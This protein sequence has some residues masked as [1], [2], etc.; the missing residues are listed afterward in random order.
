MTIH[1]MARPTPRI[2]F[3]TCSFFFRIFCKSGNTCNIIIMWWRWSRCAITDDQERA[4]WAWP[5]CPVNCPTWAHRA[6]CAGA[7]EGPGPVPGPGPRSGPGHSLNSGRVHTQNPKPKTQKKK[8]NKYP[9][10]KEKRK[11]SAIA[12][13]IQ[14]CRS[15]RSFF[16]APS[17]S[18]CRPISLPRCVPMQIQS[19][20]K[21]KKKK[22]GSTRY[23]YKDTTSTP[24]SFSFSFHIHR[25]NRRV[26]HGRKL[27]PGTIIPYIHPL[28]HTPP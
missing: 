17:R 12:Y 8:L 28:Y 19:P 22:K 25:R 13:K 24:S 23:R 10:E 1:Q 18:I 21:Q 4:S 3:Q 6:R 11:K 27:L 7:W 16:V 2:R 9:K 26:G 14:N 20:K 5:A 15:L